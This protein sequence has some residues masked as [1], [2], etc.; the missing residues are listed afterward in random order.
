[1]GIVIGTLGGIWYGSSWY[2][3]FLYL[4]LL[5]ICFLITSHMSRT[6]VWRALV[7]FGG[8]D[9]VATY[10]ITWI[11]IVIVECFSS[12]S[13]I[14]FS[15]LQL[16]DWKMYVARAWWLVNGKCLH[17]LIFRFLITCGLETC[18]WRVDVLLI[19]SHLV[20]SHHMWMKHV[21]GARLVLGSSDI[22]VSSYLVF[23]YHITW[24]Q[25]SIDGARC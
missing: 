21:C 18:I 25:V 15:S 3:V 13:F 12:C 9:V 1:M 5:L 4:M 16:L 22:A 8:S 2:L 11:G 19:T 6:C 14:Y 23:A 20:L 7:T 17:C 24:I 10:H